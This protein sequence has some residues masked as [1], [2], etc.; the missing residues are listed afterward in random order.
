M[1][2]E[3]LAYF[4]YNTISPQRDSLVTSHAPDFAFDLYPYPLGY[5]IKCFL[6]PCIFQGHEKD[7]TDTE[8]FHVHSSP[9]IYWKFQHLN[10][11]KKAKSTGIL[12][13]WQIIKKRYEFPQNK[14][15]RARLL[16]TLTSPVILWL[17]WHDCQGIKG[18]KMGERHRSPHPW[19]T[20]K[21][22]LQRRTRGLACM[23]S[24]QSN[25]KLH[26]GEGR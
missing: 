3:I 24:G 25:P 20:Y 17:H 22:C 5:L 19:I 23:W 21:L 10:R 1:C 16:H 7:N 11:R 9:L 8:R 12:A 4:P 18:R 26:E 13:G 14:H 2:F 6:Y 15:T